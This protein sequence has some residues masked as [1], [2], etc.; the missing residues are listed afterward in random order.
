[1]A[2]NDGIDRCCARNKPVKGNGIGRIEGHN[3]WFNVSRTIGAWFH[4]TCSLCPHKYCC[5][6]LFALRIPAGNAI[7]AGNSACGYDGT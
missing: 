1:M 3:E 7:N 4:P 2:R 5:H 6:F